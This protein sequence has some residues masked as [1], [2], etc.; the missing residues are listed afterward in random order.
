MPSGVSMSPCA[1]TMEVNVLGVLGGTDDIASLRDLL[2]LSP[3]AA[4]FSLDTR[5]FAADVALECITP[6]DCAVLARCSA[7]VVFCAPVAEDVALAKSTWEKACGSLAEECVRLFL[8]RETG[9]ERLDNID[10]LVA[11]AA[12]AG[13]EVLCAETCDDEVNGVAKRVREALECAEWPARQLRSQ[14]VKGDEVEEDS[15]NATLGV[16]ARKGKKL[17]THD[18]D[19]IVQSLLLDDEEDDADSESTDNNG[20]S[21]VKSDDNGKC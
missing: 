16:A 3:D 2:G 6:D 20:H 13:I 14:E 10:A 5:Y 1:C 17:G 19:R 21:S 12:V 7:V 8:A 15:A 18:I 9:E 4:T 11:W